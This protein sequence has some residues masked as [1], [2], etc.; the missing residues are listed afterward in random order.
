MMWRKSWAGLLV[1]IVIAAA[2]RLWRIDSLPPGFHLDESFE[3]LEAWRILTDPAYR[4][5]FLTGNFGVPPVNAYANALM[6]GLF[7]FFGGEAGPTAMRTTAALFGILGVVATWAA[8]TELRRLDATR[9]TT[10]FPSLPL[11]CLP[12]CAGTFIL[13]AWASNRSS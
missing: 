4:P 6:L 12:R 11:R 5:I 10:A 2:L 1:V 8:A 3:G 7:T 9:L 13:A